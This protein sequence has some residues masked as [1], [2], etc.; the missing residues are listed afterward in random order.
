MENQQRMQSTFSPVNYERFSI[1]IK[2]SG[3]Q[4]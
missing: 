4:S 2:M 3:I 1:T